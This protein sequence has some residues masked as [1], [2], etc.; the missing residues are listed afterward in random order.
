[1]NA[2]PVKRS[3]NTCQH[4]NTR[5]CFLAGIYI[6]EIIKVLSTAISQ[7][8][9]YGQFFMLQI[10]YYVKTPTFVSY[11]LVQGHS[12][13]SKGV[14]TVISEILFGVARGGGHACPINTFLVTYYFD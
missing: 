1:M 13:H 3:M 8:T 2:R 14:N 5:T 7:S 11:S 6:N 12:W 9:V 10:I 4:M